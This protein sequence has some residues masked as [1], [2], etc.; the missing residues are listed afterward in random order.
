MAGI[1]GIFRR[2]KNKVQ[3]SSFFPQLIGN[4]PL[5][6]YDYNQ[7]DF[8]T[9]GYAS[10][11][12]VY[13]I[14]KKITDKCN[15][16]KPYLYVD[17]EF[18]KSR[19]KIEEYKKSK[20]AKTS[21]KGAA[22]HR[23]YM[24]KALDYAPDTLDLTKLIVNP[25]PEQTWNE[26]ISL[27]RIFY[28]VQGEGFL[29]RESGDD[30]CAIAIYVAPAHNMHPV[31]SGEELI[32]WE[33]NL[34]NG[35]IRRFST[36]DVMHFKM[37]NP[38][39]KSA[40]GNLRGM[41][42]LMAGLK[43]LQLDDA[44]VYGWLRAME[45]EGAKGLIS[46]NH[47]NPELWLTPEQQKETEAAVETKIHGTV[48][49]NR[50][51]VSAMPLQYTHIGLSPDALNIV[52]GL[53]QANVKLCDLWNVP[54]VLFDPNPTYENLQEGRKRF[55]M[56]VVLPY[57]NT[58]EDKLNQWLVEPFRERDGKHYVID[59]DLSAYEE[60]RLYSEEIDSFLKIFSINEIRVLLGANELEDEYANQVF[61]QQGLV[62]LSDYNIS[63][64]QIM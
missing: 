14:I 42:P 41:S 3:K 18:K 43:Y 35:K 4:S 6:L 45:N 56:D 40:S 15:V 57:L 8:V 19:F 58:E 5:V 47:P 61:I 49:R 23:L 44:A 37:P 25:N 29:F 38:I 64:D 33:L 30:N 28:F 12:E 27:L 13:S 59:Y 51:V 36:D 32:G 9:K 54:A 22:F 20:S 26:L 48:N 7:E 2:K 60:L 52:K 11:A 50:V 31:L 17:D 46:P 53:N 34:M 62:P 24:Q 55:V 1:T 16:S 63:D 10:N 39:Y 21:E